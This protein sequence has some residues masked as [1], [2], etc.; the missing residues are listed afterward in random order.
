MLIVEAPKFCEVEI[1]YICAV[2]FEELLPTEYQLIFNHNIQD[3]R[4]KDS[5]T[6]GNI[7]VNSVFFNN[8]KS[9]L[10][11]HSNMP[12]LP[13]KVWDVNKEDFTNCTLFTTLPVIYGEPGIYR[14]EATTC[15]RL[16]IFGS[17]FFML[18][19]LE[20]FIC[21][22][23]DVHGR[24]EAKSSIA[25]KAG[26]L[27]RPIVDEYISI[28]GH[29]IRERFPNVEFS[30]KKFEK[31]ITCD[32]DW[33]FAPHLES[34]SAAARKSAVELIKARDI[35]S[36]VRTLCRYVYARTGVRSVDEH[37][38]ALD[39]MLNENELIG[40]TVRFYFIPFNTSRLD[41][42]E[43]FGSERMKS[44]LLDISE[45]G[46]EIGFHPG[47]QT[48]ENE[49]LFNLSV[50]NFHSVLNELNINQLVFGGRQHYLRWNAVYTPKYWEKAGFNYD[51]S[52]AYAEK[53]GFRAGTCQEYTMYD[54]R[55]RRPLNLKQRPLIT[56]E[57]TIIS[58]RYE[59][60]GLGEEALDRFL[61]FKSICKKFKGKY[62]L[63]WHNCRLVDESERE[64]YS[65]IIK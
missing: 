64:I 24:F 44:L 33:P 8:V 12:Q 61:K 18:S 41:N 45:R 56:M 34:I 49:Q 32:T 42:T 14:S 10:L 27:E 6:E 36:S 47:Y 26:F 48:F 63:L 60:M 46:H 23:K 31:I 54:V 22:E 57:D 39:W 59:G 51:S 35:K 25:V 11:C 13:L 30:G 38:N 43:N 21:S 55:E 17:V 40:N 65:E 5:E 3:F 58:S 1:K 52:L 4:L 62:T 50:Q 16:D 28:L 9:S 37:R 7:I 15:I 53:T 20:E 29:Y 19:R 2:I